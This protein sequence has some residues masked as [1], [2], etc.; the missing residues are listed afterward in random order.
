MKLVTNQ[1]FIQKYRSEFILAGILLLASVLFL[2]NLGKEG[3]SN[4]YYAA[5]VKSMLTNP[6]IIIYNSFDPAGF[7][8]IDKP[9]VSLWIQTLSA[10]LLGFSGSALI[11]PQALA[12]LCSVYLLYRLVGRSWG[13]NAGLLAAASTHHYPCL[14]G[15]CQNQ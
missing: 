6:G 4:S 8:T 7:V 12:G 5:A 1:T 11:L 2:F 9:P 3:Y 13:K 10:A 15:C 14:C